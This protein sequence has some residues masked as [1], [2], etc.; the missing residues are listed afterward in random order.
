MTLYEWLVLFLWAAQLGAVLWG[1][2]EFRKSTMR[3]VEQAAHWRAVLEEVGAGI[4]EE[5]A[6]F[7]ACLEGGT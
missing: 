5:R 7:R 3:D 6:R 1:I 2:T 4:R